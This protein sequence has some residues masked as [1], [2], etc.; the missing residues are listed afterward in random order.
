MNTCFPLCVG[1]GVYSIYSTYR[2]FPLGDEIY[3]MMRLQVCHKVKGLNGLFLIVSLGSFHL[4]ELVGVTCH[5]PPQWLCQIWSFPLGVVNGAVLCH[6]LGR[7][8][9]VCSWSCSW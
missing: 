3:K 2:A 4:V 6:G 9:F 5:H 7:T 8:I 1:W